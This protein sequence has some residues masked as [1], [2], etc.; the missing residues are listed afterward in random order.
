MSTDKPQ[1]DE[2]SDEV[3]AEARTP[4]PS[5]DQSDANDAAFT[6][7]AD[8]ESIIA[9]RDATQEKWLRAQAE[10]ENARR[11]ARMDLEELR[12]YQ[13]LPVL[14]DIL[15]VLD[16]LRLALMAAEQ[17]G[18]VDELVSGIGMVLKQFDD[19]IGLHSAKPI[20]ADGAAFDPNLHEAIQ[21]VPSPDHEPMTI[22]TEVQRGY[23][24]HDRV[25]RPSKV[26]VSSAPAEAAAEAPEPE[27]PADQERPD[28]NL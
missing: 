21:Q 23:M 20:E 12:R 14:R 22:L 25:I 28:A 26:V 3:S 18:N 27:M 2:T 6:N 5:A 17:S 19:A 13:A 10:L 8:P 15:P 4:A 11:R 9:E 7:T 16:N 1:H 24:M